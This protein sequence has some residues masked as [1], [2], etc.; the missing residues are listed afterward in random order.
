MDC[1]GAFR[2]SIYRYQDTGTPFATAE[3]AGVV[4]TG[5]RSAPAKI[6]LSFGGGAK[7]GVV[8]LSNVVE[9]L[10]AASSPLSSLADPPQEGRL[11]GQRWS[12]IYQPF[13]DQPIRGGF[14][15]NGPAQRI[16]E[17]VD[18]EDDESGKSR[19]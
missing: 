14:D 19:E 4:D 10:T 3:E 9:E 17:A 15:C 1:T 13:Q 16:V 11:A 12:Q 18:D 5:G 7:K 8:M 2:P 6:P